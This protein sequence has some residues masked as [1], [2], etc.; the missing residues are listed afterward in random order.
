[1]DVV[2]HGLM[3]I[4]VA[5]PFLAEHPLPAAC[6]MMGSVLPDLDAFSRVMGKRRF[7][8]VHQ[9]YSHALPVIAIVGAVFWAVLAATGTSSPRA[10]AALALGMIFH[11]LFDVTNTYGIR[12]LAPFSSRRFCTEWVFFIDS[13]VVAATIP[14]AGY[15]VWRMM[16]S[17]D[18]GGACRPPTPPPCPSTGGRRPGFA[19]G[20]CVAARPERS[21]FF[22]AR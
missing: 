22:R 17:G 15:V 18:A 11:S 12:L 19:A 20:R 2:T 16:T 1:M 10:A 7:L 5:S 14:T 3:G 6:F 9:T 21:P 8:Q 4:I 13:V